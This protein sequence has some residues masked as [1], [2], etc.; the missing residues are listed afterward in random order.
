MSGEE[1]TEED[2]V[3]RTKRRGGKGDLRQQSL[4]FVV[5]ICLHFM[6]EDRAEWRGK[7]RWRGK[8]GD[9]IVPESVAFSR[10]METYCMKF[11]HLSNILFS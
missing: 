4:A 7:N 2:R 3:E 1:R 10:W 6:R 8:N 9:L 5:I 11:T